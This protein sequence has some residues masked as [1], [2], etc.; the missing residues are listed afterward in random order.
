MRD[1]VV[2]PY[3]GSGVEINHDDGYGYEE[4]KTFE[5]ECGS[6]GKTFVY[7]TTIVFYYHAKK[8]KQSMDKP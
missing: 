1:D 3:C 6:C 7:T 5:Q 8:N 4:D 2:C